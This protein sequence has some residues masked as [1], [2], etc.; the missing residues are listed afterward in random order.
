MPDIGDPAP[1]FSAVDVITGETHSLSDY[2]GQ[3]VL[4][5]FSG[6]SWCPPCQFEAPVL[7][8]LW[9]DFG[10][11]FATPKVQFLMISCFDNESPQQFKTAVENFGITF[12]A[13]LNPGQAITEQYE[14]TGVPTLFV[15]NTEQKI[16]NIHVGAAPPADAVREHIYNMLIGC[17]AAVPKSLKLDLSKWAAVMSILFGVSQDGGGLGITPGGKPIPIDPSGPFMK[18]SADKKDLLLQLAIS[19]MAKGVKDYKT[20]RGIETTALKGAEAA[21]RR[22]MAL[23]E[24]APR[25]MTHI[26]AK[27]RN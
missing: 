27:P 23:N 19:E 1:H 18:L 8:D 6:P 17:G 15:V 12:P 4:L 22:I 9:N 26:S 21:M 16:C 7:V 20:A 11:S 25:D 3:V 10:G 14:V 13:L 2:A 24:L 5:I